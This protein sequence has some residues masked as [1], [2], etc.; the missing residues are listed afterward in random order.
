MTIPALYKKP[1]LL[2]SEIHRE[3]RLAQGQNYSF[4]SNVSAVFV[5]SSEFEEAGKS[6]SIVFTTNEDRQTVP[7]A[8]LG[9]REKENLCVDAFGMWSNS[10][11]PAYVRRYPFVLTQID[12]DEFGVCIE[13]K[14]INSGN[15]APLFDADGIQTKTL[16][17]AIDFLN[18]FQRD[19]QATI[20]FCSRLESNQLFQSVDIK[21]DDVTPLSIGQIKI[22][23]MK[24]INNLSNREIGSMNR[25]GDLAKIYSHAASLTNLQILF[26][27]M[28]RRI[29]TSSNL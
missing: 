8:I 1:I 15:G 20:K 22:I 11:V 26:N 17:D 5:A 16:T 2:N 23:D 24:K 4:A 27:E 19:Y 29:K 28:K 7:V 21:F 9:I 14:W 6:L 13:E 12:S 3:A 10:Y 25:N 18:L